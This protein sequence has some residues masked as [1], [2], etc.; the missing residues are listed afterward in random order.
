M[1]PS[2]DVLVKNLCLSQEF[3]G[4]MVKFVEQKGMYLYEHINSFKRFF[5]DELPDRSGFY[6]SSRGECVS[7]KDYLHAVN[8]WNL[9]TFSKR[10]LS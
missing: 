3:S 10:Q 1:N 4:E 2:L 6:S 7:E 5:D 9:F 8:V